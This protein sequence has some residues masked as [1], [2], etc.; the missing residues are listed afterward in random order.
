M[1]DINVEN[2]IITIPMVGD[3]LKYCIDEG[4][5]FE[6]EVTS[7]NMVEKYFC[8]GGDKISFN[9]LEKIKIIFSVSEFKKTVF[10]MCSPLDSYDSYIGDYGCPACNETH[11]NGHKSKICQTPYNGKCFTEIVNRSMRELGI[12]TRYFNS[13]ITDMLRKYYPEFP[14]TI[15]QGT[16]QIRFI[17]RFENRWFWF[18]QPGGRNCRIYFN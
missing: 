2:R 5:F 17:D 12:D 1:E 13:Q 15:T 16:E 18:R 8:C 3:V 7:V 4:K 11:F 14:Y 10:N 6:R 9:E